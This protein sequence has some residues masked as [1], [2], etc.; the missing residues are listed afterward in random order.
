VF[1]GHRKVLV[2]RRHLPPSATHSVF[3]IHRASRLLQTTFPASL[4]LVIPSQSAPYAICPTRHWS[5]QLTCVTAA[6]QSRS[7]R[8]A[9]QLSLSSGVGPLRHV[10]RY[11]DRSSP[12]TVK[13]TS[14]EM[15]LPVLSFQK[16]FHGFCPTSL[17][18]PSR[19]WLLVVNISGWRGSPS[20][21][22]S[23]FRRNRP[24]PPTLDLS[25]PLP[26][27]RLCIRRLCISIPVDSTVPRH[28]LPAFDNTP[29]EIALFRHHLYFTQPNQ[30]L[31]RTAYM[32]HGS[33]SELQLPRLISAVAQFGR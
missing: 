11:N 31:E 26:A 6:A 3:R 8:A 1:R 19:F 14:K 21:T 7:S 5:E 4:L 15:K 27:S 2:F 23:A 30:A 18:G 10:S 28:I 13:S 16:T 24:R 22:A 25:L 20:T 9:F 32:R 12:Q 33:C 17:T 29:I